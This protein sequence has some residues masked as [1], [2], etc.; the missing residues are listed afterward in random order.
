MSDWAES[1]RSS[2]P[3]FPAPQANC[4]SICDESPR[5]KREVVH[6]QTQESAIQLACQRLFKRGLGVVWTVECEKSYSAVG[7]GNECVKVRLKTL[8]LFGFGQGLIV[9]PENEKV[10]T[11]VEVWTSVMGIA[12][13]PQLISLGFLL[14][15]PGNRSVVISR[16]TES[17][18]LAH[19]F[20]QFICLPQVLRRQAGLTKV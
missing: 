17:L 6:L 9:L 11:Q 2:T 12:L 14:Q 3:G 13:T 16:D 5:T 10:V 19:P 8:R 15:F 18:F 4:C 1:S 7:I 20:P